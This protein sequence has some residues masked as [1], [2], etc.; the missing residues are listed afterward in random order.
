M[1][2]YEPVFEALNRE[3]VRYV[4]VG[5][6]AVVL[7]GYARL[8]ADLDLAVDLDPTEAAKA[9]GTLTGLGLRPTVPV[10]PAD[11]ADPR[12][13][14]SWVADKGMKVFSLRD[15]ENPLRAVD[16]FV[17]NPVD[18]GQLWEHSESMDLAGSAVRVASLPDLIAMKRLAGRP[19]DLED[20]EALEEILRH[21]E[22]EGG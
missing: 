21:R 19:Q 4:V 3:G 18:F 20:V 11:F 2:I 8:T 15:P 17:E 1:A 14:A 16:M 5:G 7:H 12:V 13:R 9:V 6:M 10:E 22:G